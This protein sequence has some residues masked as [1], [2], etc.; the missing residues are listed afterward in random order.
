MGL[1]RGISLP[2]GKVAEF[3]L[4]IYPQSKKNPVTTGRLPWLPTFISLGAS[5]MGIVYV[6]VYDHRKMVIIGCDCG[7]GVS[8]G[9]Y[10]YI[11]NLMLLMMIIVGEIVS[12]TFLVPG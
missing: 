8:A 10:S 12:V 9:R 4:V 5:Q 1:W 2:Y 11:E 6:K 7:T 3:Q